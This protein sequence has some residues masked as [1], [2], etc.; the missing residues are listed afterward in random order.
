MKIIALL[1]PKVRKSIDILHSQ[2]VL[3]APYSKCTLVVILTEI[4]ISHNR[5]T[6]V[7][8]LFRWIRRG[9]PPWFAHLPHSTIEAS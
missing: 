6:A 1:P 5:M 7:C 4:C 8:P 9:G 3:G 2:Y